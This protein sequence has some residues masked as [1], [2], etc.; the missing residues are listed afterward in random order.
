M[1]IK[2]VQGCGF[3]PQ[4]AC[5]GGDDAHLES[6]HWGD[7]SRGIVFKVIFNCMVEASL[8]FY[9]ILKTDQQSNKADIPTTY[10]SPTLIF[11]L[12]LLN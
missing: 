3:S 4:S 2:H 1:L 11:F 10:T 5:A 6:Q 7:G 8:V 9:E 12:S